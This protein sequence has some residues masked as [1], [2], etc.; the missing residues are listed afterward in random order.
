MN[1]G[2]E[3]LKKI[4]A[5]KIYEET[6]IPIEHVQAILNESFDSFSKIQFLGFISILE[7]EYQED[8]SE[9]KTHGLENFDNEKRVIEDKGIF[10]IPKK[11]NNLAF[12]Y[13]LLAIIVFGLV[14]YYNFSE[15]KES[16]Q[17]PALDNTLIENAQKYVEPLETNLTLE[18]NVTQETNASLEDVTDANQTLSEE[19]ITEKSESI[20]QESSVKSLEFVAKRKIWLGY[21]DMKTGEHHSKTFQDEVSIDPTKDW[22][23]IFGHGFVNIALNGKVTEFNTKDK[24]RFTYKD[25]ELTKITFNEFKSLNRGRA[26]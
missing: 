22:L 11:R 7:R 6:H 25:G 1:E 17:T 15:S 21:I 10:I 16:E 12:A 23:I 5:Q 19:N 18:S 24:L 4:G 26:W 13:I 3:R 2:L 9:L 8:L 20:T 14:V